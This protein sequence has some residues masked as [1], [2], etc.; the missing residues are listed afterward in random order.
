M[1]KWRMATDAPHLDET[2]DN[3]LPLAITHERD[4]IMFGGKIV[5]DYR[6]LVYRFRGSG[7]DISAR[8]YFDDPWTVSVFPPAP[9]S[10]IDSDVLAYLKRRF[11][12]IQQFGTPEGYTEIWAKD[13]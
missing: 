5:Q 11:N 8:M 2:D 9:D 4:T 6:F 1:P 3:N 12:R 13:A 10:T 7:G